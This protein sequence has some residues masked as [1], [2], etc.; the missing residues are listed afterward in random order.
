MAR[1]N[2][3]QS[4][5]VEKVK[6]T[7]N[8]QAVTYI[9]KRSARAKHI[10]LE[11]RQQTGLTVVVPRSYKIGRLP[12]L[13]ES[14]GRWILSKLASLPVENEPRSGDTVSYLGRDLKVVR[15]ENHGG[16]HGI[17]LVGSRLEVPPELFENGFLELVLERWYRE[18][19]AKLIK[20]RVHELSSQLGV[21]YNRLTIRGQKTRWGSCSYKK[22]L[23]FNWKLVMAPQPVIDYVIIHELA[24][25]REMNHSRKFW[26]LVAE[27]CP[28][29]RQRKKWLKEHEINLTAGPFTQR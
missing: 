12:V 21:S 29:W 24:H 4:A 20:E 14:K 18:Q 11:V 22:T 27:H 15:R 26:G 9:L 17:R 25:L 5:T 28:R 13:L 23:S 10:R 3:C 16:V 2:Y 19:A 6:T 7:I 8:G 1:E